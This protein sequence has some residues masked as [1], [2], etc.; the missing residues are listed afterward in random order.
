MRALLLA[1]ALVGCATD[2]T[3]EL[4]PAPPPGGQQ[5]ATTAYTLQPGEEKYFCWTFHSPKQAEAITA[6]QPISGKLVHHV[7]LFSTTTAEPEGFFEC[8]QLVKLNWRPIWAEG[9]GGSALT[10]PDG[11]AFQV[12]ADTQYLVQFHLLNATDKP[13]TER[14]GLNLTY[15]KDPASTMPA[16]IFALGTL[17]LDIPAGQSD[18]TLTAACNAPRDLHAFA[19]FPHMHKLGTKLEFT[20]NSQSAYSIDPWVFGNQPM[21]PIDLV[22]TQGEPLSATCHWNNTTGQDVK[23]GESTNDEMCFM[24]LFAYPLTDADGCIM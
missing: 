8:P 21:D 6:V 4:S 9:T 14:S 20:A 16:G 23:F 7:V 5:L 10:V 1:I 12:A 13:V 3:N 18:Y 24:V 11:V 15:A 17:T 19:A 22:I 2:K